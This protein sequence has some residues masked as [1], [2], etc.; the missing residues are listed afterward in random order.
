MYLVSNLQLQFPRKLDASF[1]HCSCQFCVCVNGIVLHRQ[2]R[3]D[4]SHSNF[5]FSMN[6]SYSFDDTSVILKFNK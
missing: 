6:P 5:V 4:R 3:S 1:A 2:E